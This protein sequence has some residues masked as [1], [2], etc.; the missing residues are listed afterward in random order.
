MTDND[1]LLLT[2]QSRLKALELMLSLLTPVQDG[3][4]SEED[5]RQNASLEKTCGSLLPSVRKTLVEHI[6]M[7]IHTVIEMHTCVHTPI[8]GRTLSHAHLFSLSLSLTQLILFL[9]PTPTPTLIHS[10]PYPHPDINVD[11]SF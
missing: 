6:F 8:P 2:F 5:G 11:L 4:K 3:E 10:D 9:T 7:P 1:L